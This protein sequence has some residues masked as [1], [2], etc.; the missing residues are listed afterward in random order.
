MQGHPSITHPS[1]IHPAHAVPLANGKPAT[2]WQWAIDLPR[3][4][5]HHPRQPFRLASKQWYD[6]DDYTSRILG[7][8]LPF[9]DSREIVEEAWSERVE[10]PAR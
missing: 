4:T 8:D 1:P 6:S 5:G 7:P 3:L 10:L 2:T 9:Q